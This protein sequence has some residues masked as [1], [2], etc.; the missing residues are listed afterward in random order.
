V[1]VAV[2]LS[3]LVWSGAEASQRALTPFI[4][5]TL[6]VFVILWVGGASFE[7]SRGLDPFHP[8]L[9]FT[10][11]VLIYI[12]VSSALVWLMHDYGS[13]WFYLGNHR[14]SLVNKALCLCILAC[15]FYG[16]GLRCPVWFN[17]TKR[18]SVI[19]MGRKEMDPANIRVIAYLFFFLGFLANAYYLSLFGGVDL[20]LY[21]SPTARRDSEVGVS[22][23]VVIF[24]YMLAW[25]AIFFL[26][27]MLETKVKLVPLLLITVAIAIL[28]VASGKRTAIVPVLLIPLIYFHYCVKWL[29]PTRAIWYFMI[30]ALMIV[31]G[32]LARIALPLMSLGEKAADHLGYSTMA[33]LEFYANSGEF[34]TFDMFLFTLIN[35][36]MITENIGGKLQGFLTY[37]FATMLV[38]VPRAIWPGKPEYLDLGNIYYS[39]IYGGTEV[40]FA[41]TIFSSSYLFFD[42]VGLTIGM[43]LFGWIQKIIYEWLRPFD[44]H[45]S[46]VLYYGV[47]FWMSFQGM[48]FGTFGFTILVFV[49]TM[50]VGTMAIWFIHRVKKIGIS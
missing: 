5:S 38:F 30:L 22:Q 19:G 49:Q 48:R 18:A 13:P 8:G 33:V 6:I 36:D 24:Q 47:V 28:Y 34:M 45:A 46:N 15:I 43:F 21:L 14:V 11:F 44:G 37:S 4:F 10:A 27:L 3:I 32:V 29:S 23:L 35:T 12:G 41:V 17:S 7:L 2:A 31:L 26:I 39:H 25:S 9:L 20:L 50:L 42:L 1:V 40:G 16:L